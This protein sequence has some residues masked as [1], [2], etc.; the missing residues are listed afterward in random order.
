MVLKFVRRI[1]KLLYCSKYLL[2]K[3]HTKIKYFCN[4]TMTHE[5]FMQRCLQLAQLGARNVAPNPMVGCV[6]VVDG[7]IIGEGYHMHYGGAHAEVN[8]IH[9]VDNKALLN[10]ATVYVSLEPCAH[11][12]ITPPCA[13]LLIQY[14]VKQVVVGCLDPHAQV[15]GKG[16]EKLK[17]AGIE[18][19]VG[20]LEND[21]IELNKRFITFH[22]KQRPYIILKWAETKDG[23]IAGDI[24]QIS[25]TLAQQRLHIWRSEEVAFMI[26]T[27]TLL[28][29]NPALS[30]RLVE[31]NNP[32][33]IAVDAELK[34]VDK[35]LKFYDQSQTT[36]IINTVKNET[37]GLVEYIK[38]DSTDPKSLLK[39]L[40]EQNILSVVIEGGAQFL[41]SFL[42]ANLYDEIRVIKSKLLCFEAGLH[43]PLNPLN[44]L[45]TEDLGEDILSI[46]QRQ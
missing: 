3:G 2:V 22:Q 25:G 10:Q 24:K 36:I 19:L 9:S 16:I 37:D 8:A 30:V 40:F 5:Y 41:Q 11:F 46:Y 45:I 17:L 13:D 15:A 12:G 31:G 18:V 7:K 4:I 39:V 28:Q 44:A 38:V 14:K 6:I 35:A 42:D 33:R 27:N 32:I 43:A 23:F 1:E 29:D 34:S 20:I 26:G 21:C